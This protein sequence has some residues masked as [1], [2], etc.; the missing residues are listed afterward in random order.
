MNIFII[1]LGLIGGSIA[2]DLIVLPDFVVHAY[3]NDSKAIKY[4]LSNNIIDVALKSVDEIMTYDDGIIMLCASPSQIQSILENHSEL[5]NSQFSVT[6]VSS[7][8]QGIFKALDKID[9]NNFIFSHPVAGSHHSGI[10]K[11]EPGLFN[12][13]NIIISFNNAAKNHIEKIKFIWTSIGGII[14]KIDGNKH[15]EYF[16]LTSHLPHLIAY[17]MVMTLQDTDQNLKSF[18][19]GGLSEFLRLSSSSP[20]MWSDIFKDNI[21][22]L[23]SSGQKFIKNL[24]T[25]LNLIHNHP[26][27]VLNSLEEVQSFTEKN[28]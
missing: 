27:Q 25:L 5:I 6:D 8:K 1:G 26:D 7:V 11:S 4:A 17:A 24:R 23:D 28:F 13:K 2:R 21:G 9:A 19:A 15:D 16:A 12:G 10:E 14:L 22:N 3:D 18:A 20:K